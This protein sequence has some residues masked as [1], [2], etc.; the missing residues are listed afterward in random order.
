MVVR[1]GLALVAVG[2]VIGLVAA[3][4]LTRV[5][6]S[7]LF[8]VEPTDPVTFA[9]IIVPIALAALAASWVPARR[10]AKVAPIEA[11]RSE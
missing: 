10:A 1:Q 2:V 3:L 11:L 8:D 5:F 6:R 9:A 7:L 4:A